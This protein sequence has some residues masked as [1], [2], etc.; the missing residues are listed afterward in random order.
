VRRCSKLGESQRSLKRW[1]FLSNKG[2]LVRFF[3]RFTVKG[4]R[5]FLCVCVVS[6]V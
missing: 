1:A 4:L 2:L 5:S 6:C 3:L